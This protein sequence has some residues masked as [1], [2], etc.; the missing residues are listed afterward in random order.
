MLALLL[1]IGLAIDAGSLYSTYGQL[2]RAIDA[3][4]VASANEFKKGASV[5]QMQAAAAEVLALHN[6]DMAQ[7]DMHVYICDNDSTPGRDAYLQTTVPRFYDLCPTTAESPKKLV[8]VDAIQRAPFYFLSLLGFQNV[9]LHTDAVAEAAPIDL[10]IVIDTSESMAWETTF[11]VAV[12]NNDIR[13]RYQPNDATEGCNVKRNTPAELLESP[14]PAPHDTCEPLRSAK[15][16]AVELIDQLYDGFDRVAIVTFDTVG[17]AHPVVTKTDSS[18]YSYFSFNLDAA[19]EVALNIKLHDDPPYQYLWGDWVNSGFNPVNPEDR[20]GDGL[21]ADTRTGYVCTPDPIRRSVADTSKSCDLD[22]KLDAY[23]WNTVDG[24]YSDDDHGTAVAWYGNTI[25]DPDRFA[26][27]TP[28]GMVNPTP[29]VVNGTLKPSF[30]PLSTCTGCGIR[31]ANSLF[32]ASG[33]IGGRPGAVWVMVFL[34]DGLANFSDTVG[35]GGS[36]SGDTLNSL[37]GIP[38]QYVNGYCGG[39]LNEGFWQ[40]PIFCTDKTA[41]PRYCL[42]STPASCPPGAITPNPANALTTNFYSPLDYAYDMVDL[43]ALTSSTN[44]NEPR[45]NDIAVYTIGLGE[46]VIGNQPV[47]ENLLR[48]MAAVGDDGDRGTNPCTGIP[49][50]TSCGNYYF[51]NEGGALLAI[52]EDIA[53]RIYTRI[54]Q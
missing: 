15:L 49:A 24:V 26:L 37:G 41:V 33:G 1:F 2:K 14:V 6:V 13:T 27:P 23:N 21:D 46:S 44:T 45:G 34:S 29:I 11:P 32:S 51:A 7:V 52:F 47:A 22:G 53:S 3:A 43:L 31:V 4:A 30:S 35:G 50:K 40:N 36:S 48:Y 54:S 19:K 10:V 39:R 9:P 17:V 28:T 16:A 5:E 25:N 8:W 18:V 20:D 12:D 42:D 38:T